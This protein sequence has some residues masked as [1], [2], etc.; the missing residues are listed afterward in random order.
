MCTIRFKLPFMLQAKDRLSGFVYMFCLF[1]L[2]QLLFAQEDGLVASYTFN[3][4]NTQNDAG[5]VPAK[6]VGVT[7]GDDR[8]GNSRSACFLNGSLRSYLNLGTGPELKPAEGTVSLWVKMMAE[9]Y[10]GQGYWCNPVVL[11]KNAPGDDFFEAYAIGYDLKSKRIGASASLSSMNQISALSSNAF[12]LYEWHHVVVTWSDTLLCF[13]VDGVQESCVAKNFRTK[14]LNTD[15]VLIGG[16]GNI[17]NQRFFSGYVDDISIYNHPLSAEAVAELYTQGD[18]NRYRNLIIAV[19]L[20]LS[21][22]ALTI[23]LIV[24]KFRRALEREKEKNRIQ[25]QVFEMETRVIK[26]QM[27]PHFIFN[28]MNSI[29]QFILAD[30]NVNANAYLVKFS[31]LLRKIL[32]SSTDEYI[33]LENELEILNKYIEI[34]SLRFDRAFTYEITVDEKL[35]RGHLRIPHMLVQ[36][37][38]EN[39]I[40]HGLLNKESDKQLKIEFNYC[41]TTTVSCIIDDNGAGRKA[42]KPMGNVT[43]QKSLG[44][45]F[46]AQRLEL[47]RKEWGGNYGVEIVDKLNEQGSSAGTRVIMTIP[48]LKN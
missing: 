8:F 9:V 33:S 37:F 14:Y 23:L 32:E 40:W 7:F 17:K 6:G 12:E 28:S 11:T 29:Q 35:D 34:E 22:I 39:A 24:R 41:D 38:V 16:S 10:S 45:H 1:F 43:K 48:I 21:V 4:G 36:P 19:L 30:D 47:M 44:V 3:S 2:P 42:S 25:R 31:K 26:A 15:S 27:N 20:T 46:T 18:P 13:Y 5:G